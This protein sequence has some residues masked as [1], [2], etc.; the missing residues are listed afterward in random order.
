[1]FT[2]IYKVSSSISLARKQGL[3]NQIEISSSDWV[4]GCQDKGAAQFYIVVKSTTREYKK[5]KYAALFKIGNIFLN[6][7]VG[8]FLCHNNFLGTFGQWI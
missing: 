1:M 5:N 7:L 8:K 2:V 4:E 6:W 3:K